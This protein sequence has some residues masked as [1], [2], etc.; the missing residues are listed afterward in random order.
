MNGE[1]LQHQDGH[2]QLLAL[3]V[4]KLRAYDPAF[5]FELTVIIRDGI[6]RMYGQGEDVFYYLTVTNQNEVIAAFQGWGTGEE[7]AVIDGGILRGLYAFEHRVPDAE[8]SA[9]VANCWAVARS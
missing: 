4:P 2:S 7:G 8:A 9:P 3:T 1:G 5:A 6:E